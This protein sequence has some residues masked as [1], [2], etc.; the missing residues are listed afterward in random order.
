F[1]R[2]TVPKAGNWLF[3]VHPLSGLDSTMTVFDTKGNLVGGT[4]T[5]PIDNP[6]VGN[7]ET[8]TQSMNA[9]QQAVVRV[10]GKGTSTGWYIISARL[11]A[12]PSMTVRAT[13]TQARAGTGAPAKFTIV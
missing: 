10:D 4:F 11:L 13:T 1:W 12:Q 9:G 2:I 8:F 5:T 7:I 6:G 3:G